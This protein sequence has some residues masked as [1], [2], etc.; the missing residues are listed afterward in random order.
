MR[1]GNSQKDRTSLSEKSPSD[2]ETKVKTESS[3]DE[4]CAEIA[5][6]VP[7][8]DCE[9][10][11]SA[12]APVMMQKEMQEKSLSPAECKD[13]VAVM[14]TEEA[15]NSMKDNSQNSL[16]RESCELKMPDIL[17]PNAYRD[18]GLNRNTSVMQ[19]V[20]KRKLDILKEGGLEV[21]P[22]TSFPL[23]PM[24][25]DVRPS[26]IQQ[27]TAPIHISGGSV[28][29]DKQHMP[30]PSLPSKRQ[31]QLQ[32]NIPQ[33]PLVPSL[34]NLSKPTN[35][36][37]TFLYTGDQL[38]P[39]VVQSRS[40]YSYSEKTVYGNPKD[41]FTPPSQH[42]HS[43][44]FVGASIKQAGG[45]ILDLRVTSPQKPVVEIMRIPT[46]TA[47]S[48]VPLN[49]KERQPK[50]PI[51]KQAASVP[52]IEGKRIGSNLEITLVGPQNKSPYSV[53]NQLNKYSLNAI[54]S[55][56]YNSVR[57]LGHKRTYSES[58]AYNKFS[59][60]EENG[61]SPRSSG[62][63]SYTP[64]DVK[65]NNL[66]ITVPNPYVKNQTLKQDGSSSHA[67]PVAHTLPSSNSKQLT[68]AVP[69][70]FPNYLPL[71]SSA[72]KNISPYLPM[73]DPIYY[74]A[75]QSM[76][77]GNALPP[78]PPMFS[79]PTPEQLQIYTELMA[80]SARA[81]FPFPFPDG[82]TNATP[83]NSNLKKL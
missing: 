26:V 51:K 41:L 54:P 45:D 1:D 6:A 56:N 76:Y 73:I 71:L 64:K 15:A 83:E 50:G 11:T 7:E 53:H 20:K 9:P 3:S 67:K 82:S 52:L 78:T 69:P 31:V 27:A 38:P 61:R 17:E 72:N 12:V 70:V 23:S 35:K 34:Q 77:P 65:S 74:S 19:E 29:P 62:A 5:N 4:Y 22:V 25:K 44:R 21:T 79:M 39:K 57:K 63:S 46:V 33:I 68:N 75:L 60:I 42:V 37:G 32:N 2:N 18:P 36:P 48:Q 28:I 8:K 14:N 13:D 49:L 47:A 59:R 24:L 16:A 40:I 66:E 58:Y 80:Q 10:V 55:S 30:P 81:R 43:P